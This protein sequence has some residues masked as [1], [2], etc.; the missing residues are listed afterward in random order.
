MKRISV[1][2]FLSL[3]FLS[4]S[5]FA[6]SDRN[7]QTFELPHRY[8]ASNDDSR[9]DARNRAIEEAQV[10][11]LQELG[12]LV[13]ARQ[14]LRSADIG[15]ISQQEFLAEVNTYTLGRVQTTVVYG[16]EIWR[17]NVF[18]ATFRMTVDTADLSRHLNAILTQRQRARADSIA[19]VERAR[20]DSV[21]RVQRIATLENAAQTAR[22]I[23]MQESERA[24]PLQQERDRSARELEEARANRDNAQRAFAN[25]ATASDA[26]TAIGVRRIE[27]ERALLQETTNRYN[28]VSAQYNAAEENLRA[29][30][31]RLQTAQNNLRIAENNLAQE[32]GTPL[33]PESNFVQETRPSIP[34]RNDRAPVQTQPSSQAQASASPRRTFVFTLATPGFASTAGLGGAPGAMVEFGW[35]NRKNI[36]QSVNALGGFP[37]W[38]TGYSIGGTV[39]RDGKATAIFGGTSGFYS[40]FSYYD[41]GDSHG[42]TF[43]FSWLGYFAKMMIGRRNNFDITL[44]GLF[45]MYDSYYSYSSTSWHSNGWNSWSNTNWSNGYHAGFQKTFIFSLGWAWVRR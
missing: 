15:G 38:G 1:L 27:N 44:R 32:I 4:F 10:R 21:A 2:V 5:A 40:A 29:A 31:A 3:C 34:A 18:S 14:R 26:H 33:A 11:L 30:S 28:Q 35:I 7:I 17:D 19:L 37:Y 41:Y 43:V 25:V 23:F 39:N 20:A 45:G 22:R 16:T 13:E 8:V 36:Y 6:R 24:R 12:V 9:N 42:D